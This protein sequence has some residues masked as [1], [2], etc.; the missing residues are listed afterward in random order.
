SVLR[1]PHKKEQKEEA[2]LLT[3]DGHNTTALCCSARVGK[4]QI[5]LILDS[6]AS[7]SVA[8]KRFLEDIG[9]KSQRKSNISLTN[10]H[11]ESRTPLGAI[12]NLPLTVGTVTTPIQVDIT[13]SPRYSIIVGNDW[14]R[15]VKASIN[16]ETVTLTIKHDRRKV[17]IP[18]TYLQDDTGRRYADKDNVVEEEVEEDGR[19]ES[20][21]E[22][23]AAYLNSP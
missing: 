5:T 14:M 7:G 6:G 9:Y 15:K 1:K 19:E 22:D 11:G 10:I 17:L 3:E 21:E 23:I 16:Y 13:E 4:H 20:E 12:D 2:N 8:S 18:C